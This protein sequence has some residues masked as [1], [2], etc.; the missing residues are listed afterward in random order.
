MKLIVNRDEL[1]S[2]LTRLQGF[3]GKSNLSPILSNV[4]IQADEG[5]KITLSAT[6]NE[7][8]FHGYVNAQVQTPGALTVSGK[9][10]LAMV[11]Q[12]PSDQVTLSV[13]ERDELCLDSNQSHM[14]LVG[15]DAR[16]FPELSFGDD[17]DMF[18][19]RGGVLT[20]LFE[21]TLFSASAD[22]ARA[23]LNGV[24]FTSL[25]DGVIRVVSTDGHRLS[26]AERYAGIDDAATIPSFE[27]QIIPRKA[28]TEL[29]KLLDEYPEVRLVIS[30]QNLIVKTDDFGI[31][32]R[33]IAERFPPYESVIPEYNEHTYIFDRQEL[34]SALKRMGLVGEEKLHG[35]ELMFSGSEVRLESKNNTL[36][37][38]SETLNLAEGSS[39]CELKVA[40]GV[41]YM[42]DVLNVIKGAEV[43]IRLHQNE[44]T[45]GLF[46]DP[47]FEQDTFVVMPKRV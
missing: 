9:R 27:G 35:V 13:T 44:S 33:L 6:D 43:Q 8:S 37:Q 38:V 31:N 20:D 16:E 21:R 42:I 23:N 4:L 36:G 30:G 11:R 5:G 12:F 40:F 34:L 28:V 19:L 1:S 10:L 25:G 3:L 26:L 41:H 39:D 46:K 29:R 45:P 15:I 24:L 2:M 18:V 17:G 7:I 47:E 32:I 14:V 22:E